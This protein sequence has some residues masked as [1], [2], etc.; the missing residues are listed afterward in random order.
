MRRRVIPVAVLAATIAGCGSAP[1]SAA[2]K[3]AYNKCVYEMSGQRLLATATD[4]QV[5]RT[6]KGM[7]KDWATDKQY[8][9]ALLAACLRHPNP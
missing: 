5:L 6:A 7:V 9:T 2:Q 4:A 1:Q 8:R 3:A